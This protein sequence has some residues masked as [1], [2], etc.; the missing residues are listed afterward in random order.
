MNAVDVTR[1]VDEIVAP[2]LGKD[3]NL[4]MVLHRIQNKYGYVPRAIALEVAGRLDVPL[5]RIYEVI[6]FYNYFKL[7]APGDHIVSV[8]M[9]TACY[10]K[11]A[12]AIMQALHD[13]LGIEPGQ[14]TPDGKFHLQVVRCLGCCGLSPVL[15]A[16]QTVHGR[17]TP[18]QIPGIIKECASKPVHTE[19]L[20]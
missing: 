19:S 5:A 9:G 1:E 2:W 18:E 10:L 3:G 7:T 17:V 16:D 4:I 6:T 11:G 20:S 15:T 8:C 14:T 13:E 12:K